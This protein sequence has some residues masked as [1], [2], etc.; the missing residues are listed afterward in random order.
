ME[1]IR[2]KFSFS[3]VISILFILQAIVFIGYYNILVIKNIGLFITSISIM[4]I[5]IILVF[6]KFNV[7]IDNIG[8]KY[9]I[10]PCFIRTIK[11]E[12]IKKYEI[13]ENDF[14]EQGIRYSRKFGWGYIFSSENI[15]IITNKN[16]KKTC[17]S[18]N[19]KEI[20]ENIIKS[21]LY[22]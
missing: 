12:D 2:Q 18:V 15:L 3:K 13:V 14:L 11:W 7:I 21:K 6:S 16:E 10:K 4:I 22:K 5:G 8:I 19:D 9:Q 1:D 17:L 20:I